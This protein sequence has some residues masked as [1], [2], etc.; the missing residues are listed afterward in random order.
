MLK[1]LTCTTRKV[2]EY[3][4]AL[5]FV[6]AVLLSQVA[7][8]F[9]NASLR[10]AHAYMSAVC[11]AAES[12]RAC[13]TQSHVSAHRVPGAPRTSPGAAARDLVLE[14]AGPRGPQQKTRRGTTE[15][16]TCA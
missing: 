14:G 3:V 16:H 4:V 9:L 10:M 7:A 1:S 11:A 13:A 8:T 12:A 5:A 6:S 2:L 15:A